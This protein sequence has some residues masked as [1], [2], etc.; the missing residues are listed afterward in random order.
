MIVFNGGVVCSCMQDS[1][2][3]FFIS[4]GKVR[5]LYNYIASKSLWGKELD[6]KRIIIGGAF[7]FPFFPFFCLFFVVGF[8]F[9]YI[10][11]YI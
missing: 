8:F 9:V 3:V 4:C 5:G 11:I 7:F 1:C 2:Q 6:E 10:Y